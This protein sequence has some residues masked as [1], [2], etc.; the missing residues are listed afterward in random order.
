[1]SAATMYDPT[2]SE[3]AVSVRPDEGV[4]IHWVDFTVS[5]PH[6]PDSAV[7]RSVASSSYLRT[8]P[9]PPAVTITVV[10][11]KSTTRTTTYA[12]FKNLTR[13]HVDNISRVF[14]ICAS[15]LND[16]LEANIRMPLLRNNTYPL[17]LGPNTSCYVSAIDQLALSLPEIHISV[18]N[19][20]D[21]RPKLSFGGIP[22]KIVPLISHLT[23]LVIPERVG[24]QLASGGVYYVLGDGYDEP[25]D[26][27]D[28]IP[29]LVYPGD[30]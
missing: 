29:S 13:G 9:L 6:G 11:Y 4:V 14:R 10:S 23:G 24:H 25:S 17:G 15:E 19:S 12:L 26:D 16:Q 1:M 30:H 27:Y 2:E 21:G 8:H 3:D 22:G 20:E 5:P 18:R 28:D 7:L